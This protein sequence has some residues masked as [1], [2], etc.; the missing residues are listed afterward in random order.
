MMLIEFR[1]PSSWMLFT[2]ESAI[3]AHKEIVRQGGE[4]SN[5]AVIDGTKHSDDGFG[6]VVPDGLD[7]DLVQR[8]AR[9]PDL[10]G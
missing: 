9:A 2:W 6:L 10:R 1:P 5:P 7:L 3:G 8:A 4:G